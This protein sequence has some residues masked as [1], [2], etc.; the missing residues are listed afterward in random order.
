[1]RD[2]FARRGMLVPASL[3]AGG[4]SAGRKTLHV[5][6]A[7][8][9]QDR[10]TWTIENLAA[11]RGSRPMGKRRGPHAR[12][13]SNC[14]CAGRPHHDSPH[15][16]HL[17][18]DLQSVRHNTCTRSPA[19]R[20]LKSAATIPRQR[21]R[22]RDRINFYLFDTDQTG[23]WVSSHVDVVDKFS[24][25]ET[26]RAGALHAQA[27][28]RVG[29]GLSPIQPAAEGPLA[30]EHRGGSVARLPRDGSAQ[31]RRRHRRRTVPGRCQPVVFLA[32]H[33]HS[34]RATRALKAHNDG[35]APGLVR[36]IRS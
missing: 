19:S 16:I 35:A 10:P 17:R 22:D 1:M 11:G 6:C 34:A 24:P 13:S 29:H 21:C 36:L 12:R 3:V 23:G 26:P 15:W 28:F 32:A 14:L 30:A 2:A 9:A 25:G 8:G 4:R 18:G 31:S 5:L 20:P 33:D 27:R 7:P